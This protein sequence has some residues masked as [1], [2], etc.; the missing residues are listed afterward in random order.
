MVWPNVMDSI[1]AYWSGEVVPEKSAEGDSASNVGAWVHGTW[2]TG[3]QSWMRAPHEAS[4]RTAA[5]AMRS[6]RELTRCRITNPP[7]Q[8][9]NQAHYNVGKSD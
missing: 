3:T 4:W 8:Q 1:K 9:Y 5:P 7:H 2:V 6:H